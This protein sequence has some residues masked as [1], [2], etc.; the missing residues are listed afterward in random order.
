MYLI[1]APFQINEDFNQNNFNCVGKLAS[2]YNWMNGL[3]V[4]SFKFL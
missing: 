4:T 1:I 2:S 3:N